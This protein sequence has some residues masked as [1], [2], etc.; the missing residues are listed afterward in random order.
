MAQFNA[1][2]MT[3][4]GAALLAGALAGTAQISF[5]TMV[6]GNGVYTEEEKA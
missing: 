4:E 3:N 2:V 6:T 1:A 5:T